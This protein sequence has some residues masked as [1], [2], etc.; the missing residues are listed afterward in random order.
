MM[1]DIL[2]MCGVELVSV[3]CVAENDKITLFAIACNVI[4]T[5]AHTHI[6][7]VA[8][9]Q[10]DFRNKDDSAGLRGYV[11]FNKITHTQ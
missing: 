9:D 11:R 6:P 1:R 5:H 10:R 7:F 3:T 4:S 8:S 2:S